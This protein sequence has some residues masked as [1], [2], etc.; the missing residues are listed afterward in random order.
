M[1]EGFYKIIRDRGSKILLVIDEA[2]TMGMTCK[3][4]K[5]SD[6]L[7]SK[8]SDLPNLGGSSAIYNWIIAQNTHVEDLV[9]NKGIKNNYTRL[10]LISLKKGEGQSSFETMQKTRFITDCKYSWH[11]VR[12]TAEKSSRKRAFYFSKFECWLPMP[13]MTNDSGYDRDN[14]KYLP[15]NQPTKLQS[16]TPTQLQG[17]KD[18][19]E[20][21]FDALIAAPTNDIRE[22]IRS[23]NPEVE[24]SV[25][26]DVILKIRMQEIARNHRQLLDKFFP[27]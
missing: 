27:A 1:W 10:G 19:I 22:A 20:L 2:T 12:V 13:E 26:D 4:V 3:L 9:I 7:R 6:E 16:G 25:I 24:E 21:V 8:I 18:E 15:Q 23:A 17:E 5:K 11:D 14:D